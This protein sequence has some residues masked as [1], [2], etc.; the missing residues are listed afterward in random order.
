MKYIS[1]VFL[2]SIYLFVNISFAEGIATSLTVHRVRIDASGMGYVWFASAL[3]GTPAP[4]G[5]SHPNQLS[6]DTTTDGG[7]AILSMALS[8]KMSGKSI[9]ASGTNSCEGYNSVERW[10]VGYLED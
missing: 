9:S 1:S 4:C 5:T 2:V 3:T 6:F 7:K 10:S 8:A